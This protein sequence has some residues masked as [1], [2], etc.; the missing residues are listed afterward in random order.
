[1]VDRAEPVASLLALFTYFHSLTLATSVPSSHLLTHHSVAPV[2][3]TWQQWSERWTIVTPLGT[4]LTFTPR[5]YVPR[6]PRVRTEGGMPVPH[7]G[8]SRSIHFLHHGSLSLS[9]APTKRSRKR[10]GNAIRPKE[11][12]MRDE[13]W[14]GNEESYHLARQVHRADSSHS[15]TIRMIASWLLLIRVTT[16]SSS[17][18][19][20]WERS[21]WTVRWGQ[22][23]WMK[24]K[25]ANPA[26]QGKFNLSF[27][28]LCSLLGAGR[29]PSRSDPHGGAPIWELDYIFYNSFRGVAVGVAEQ[30]G[31]K[32]RREPR[33]WL[34]PRNEMSNDKEWA[35]PSPA[36]NKCKTWTIWIDEMGHHLPWYLRSKSPIKIYNL[37]HGL[38]PFK[39]RRSPWRPWRSGGWAFCSHYSF[40]SLCRSV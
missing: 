30:S 15:L 29:S 19:L 10:E 7:V 8:R 14:G 17:L 5:G 25:L 9:G 34:A 32:P 6:V 26:V 23:T 11:R 40:F 4:P 21:M 16:L 24:W 18:V 3:S 37:L 31:V 27:H 2:A 13:G 36:R 22:R 12:R 20:W 28:L 33:E 35:S 39:E 38:S 1:M